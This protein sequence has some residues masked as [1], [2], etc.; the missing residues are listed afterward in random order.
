MFPSEE[1]HSLFRR[2]SAFDALDDDEVD[3]FTLFLRERRVEA[4]AILFREGDP[5]E[6]LF[7][8]LEGEANV[9]VRG[10]GGDHLRVATLAAGDVLG[11]RSCID[12]SPRSATV[13]ATS[14]VRALELSRAELDRM[15]RELP[16]VASRLLGVIAQA[17]A[18]RLRSVERKIDHELGVDEPSDSG[19][20]PPP[21][22]VPMWKRFAMRF[23]G[24]R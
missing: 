13:T 2:A 11:E 21:D 18:G 9:Y 5:G 24:A 8:L 12:P 22:H 14:E 6:S 15:I 20:P 4:G 17:L 23:G 10:P 7:V 1:I 3:A 19:E 16:S